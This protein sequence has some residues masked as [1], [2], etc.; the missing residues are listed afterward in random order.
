MSPQKTM[1]EQSCLSFQIMYIA[2]L[3]PPEEVQL[4]KSGHI[5]NSPFRD[6]FLEG[7]A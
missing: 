2:L 1:F 5:E 6:N 4:S 3:G 7:A